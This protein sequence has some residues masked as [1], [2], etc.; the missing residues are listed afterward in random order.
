MR[1]PN[2]FGCVYK[3]SGNRRKPYIARIT[4]GWDEETGKQLFKNIGSFPT[5]KEAMSALTEYN[6]DPY[7]IDA[8]RITFAEVY[9][10]WSFNKFPKISHSM[11][12]SYKNAFKACTPIHDLPF[13]T[14]KK[15]QI[16]TVI[17]DSDKTFSG[18]ERMKMLI[19]QMFDYAMEC[20]IVKKNYCK[21]EIDLGER[22]ERV[23]ARNPYTAEEIEKL[24][25]S[26]H[27]Y[28]YTDTILM[29]IF[30]GV[31]P[32]ELLLVE[33]EKVHL[34]ENYFIC[35]IKNSSSKNRK[36]P[37]SKFV[38]PF[39]EKY[40]NAAVASGSKWLIQNTEGHQMKYSNY[41][42]DKY[43]KIMEQLELSHM[44]HDGRHTFAT[45][46]DAAGANKLCTQLIMGHSPKVLIDSV[47][48]HKTIAELQ[49]E[50][51]K[52]ENLFDYQKYLSLVDE[53]YYTN[54]YE[55]LTFDSQNNLLTRL[56]K[57]S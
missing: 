20:D 23:L 25:K 18:K 31:R 56:E 22:P 50:I 42:R 36:V 33:T 5:Y 2:G 38:R 37:I 7:D 26:L 15:H 21:C 47:Y 54:K 19:S 16:Q 27:I 29:M 45:F 46:M 17:T 52:I 51:D 6:T 13:V 10:K 41:N 24:Y 34:D 53:R 12:L 49:A 44:P 9:E 55:F 57:C 30:S 35:G 3:A 4:V 48:V 40:Y 28:R 14:I 8:S 39:F 1:N 43:V 11:M 32:S